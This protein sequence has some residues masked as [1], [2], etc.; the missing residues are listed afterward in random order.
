MS[1]FGIMGL[2]V[3]EGIAGGDVRGMEM[4]SR[5]RCRGNEEEGRRI[6]EREGKEIDDVGKWEE[7]GWRERKTRRGQLS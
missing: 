4:G 3:A 2:L 1:T 7:K 6:E 5:A